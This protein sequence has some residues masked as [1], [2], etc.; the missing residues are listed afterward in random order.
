VTGP[1]RPPIGP[2]HKFRL[3]DDVWEALLVEARTESVPVAEIMRRI[4]AERYILTYR[5][6]YPIDRCP[7]CGSTLAPPN[8]NLD[9]ACP[10]CRYTV[11][12]ATVTVTGD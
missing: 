3:P 2:A 11:E 5:N 12:A 6:P 9:R 4:L 10:D 1:G 8:D 7:H